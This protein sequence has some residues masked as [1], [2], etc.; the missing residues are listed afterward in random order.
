MPLAFDN[1]FA[2]LGEGFFTRVT[3]TPLL[4]PSLGLK[5]PDAAAL[6]GLD[7]QHPDTLALMGGQVMPVGSDP[8]AQVYAGHQFGGFSP[9]LGDGRGLLIGE[10]A[11]WD[12]HLKGAGK[13]PY[14]RFGDGR[15]VIRSTVREFIASEYL[16]AVG[17]PTT[18]AAVM[19]VSDTPVQRERVEKGA[20]LLRL[21]RTHLRFGHFE[22]FK[23]QGKTAE[24]AALVDHAVARFDLAPGDSPA[25]ALFRHALHSNAALVAQW[26]GLG[27]CHGVM[28]TDNT[29]IVGDT[30]DFGP[31]GFMD[32]HDAEHVC[33][34]SDHQGRYRFENQPGVMKWNLACLAEALVPLAG[35]EPLRMALDE[36]D[37]AFR[38]AYRDVLHRRLGPVSDDLMLG[39]L[40]LLETGADHTLAY[41][42]QAE[43]R[44]RK[45]GHYERLLSLFD[46]KHREGLDRWL[47]RLVDEVPDFDARASALVATNPRRVPRNWICQRIIDWAEA[48]D[49]ASAQAACDALFAPFDKA[50]PQWDQPP[51][52]SL[53]HL[54]VSCSS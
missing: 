47:A 10:V 5:S 45:D 27:F 37:E 26:Q 17:V 54:A 23:T 52:E 40:A 20:S 31:F 21:A 50:D 51:P 4:N 15:A 39:W 43:Y 14:S 19:A 35:I 3:P 12:L 2:R 9:R 24:L 36:F 34:H 33:N 18:R 8:L 16:A 30:I 32:A 44:G 25:L 6:I 48:G 1:A 41:R 28:N 11:G 7:L 42:Y 22:Y 13:T 53:R 29:S 49:W 46:T 38:T